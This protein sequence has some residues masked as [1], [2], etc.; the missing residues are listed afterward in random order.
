MV[1]EELAPLSEGA[2]YYDG[3]SSPIGEIWIAGSELG[4]VKIGFPASEE[5][6]LSDLRRISASKPL[7]DG[8]R[9]AGIKGMLEEYFRGGR[10]TFDVPMDLRGT[11][12]QMMVWGAISR[13]PYGGLSSYGRIAEEIGRPRAVRAVG[14]AVGANPLPIVIPCHRIIRA[15]GGLGGYG[16]GRDLKL[17]LL[18]LEGVVERGFRWSKTKAKILLDNMK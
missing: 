5:R 16:G 11:E 7:R 2:L 18:A 6:F 12:F 14:N 4:L 1:G 9:F 3:F 10:V 13:V 17:Y 8:G 15:D